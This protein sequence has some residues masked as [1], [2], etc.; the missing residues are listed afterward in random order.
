MSAALMVEHLGERD[1]AERLMDAIGA[2]CRNGLLTR[3]VGG[4]ATTSEVGDAVARLI[5][6]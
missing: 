3:D 2:C 6:A 1:A 5:A 4:T